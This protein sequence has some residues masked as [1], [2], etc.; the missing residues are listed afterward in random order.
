MCSVGSLLLLNVTTENAIM[1]F[2]V[3]ICS[4]LKRFAWK[5]DVSLCCYQHEI[6]LTFLMFPQAHKKMHFGKPCPTTSNEEFP[7]GIV[8]GAKWYV[9]SGGMQDWNYLNSNCFEITLEVGCYKFPPAKQLPTF[10][11]DNREALLTYI[12]AVSLLCCFRAVSGTS[13]C[14]FRALTG[15]SLCCFRALT[16]T[17][18]CCFRALTGTSLCCFRAVTGTA[19][20]KIMK[21]L[22]LFCLRGVLTYLQSSFTDLLFY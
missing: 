11:L 13:L 15:T 8:N 21:W 1:P 9:V 16:V 7:G 18:L 3:K 14:Y 4:E 20:L 6:G 12:E 19:V 2:L 5:Y 17:S 10:W 22:C